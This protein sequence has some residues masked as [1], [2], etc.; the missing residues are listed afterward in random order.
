MTMRRFKEASLRFD[1][2]GV[3]EKNAMQKGSASGQVSPRHGG[4]GIPCGKTAN[5]VGIRISFF[6]ITFPIAQ[7][8]RISKS[9]M[10]INK[11]VPSVGLQAG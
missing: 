6:M 10:P 8:W 5:L 4:V 9:W 11:P 2:T 1:L 7:A 3:M